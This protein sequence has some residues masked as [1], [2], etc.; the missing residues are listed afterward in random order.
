MKETN[1]F[2]IVTQGPDALATYRKFLFQ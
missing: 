2:R 1:P